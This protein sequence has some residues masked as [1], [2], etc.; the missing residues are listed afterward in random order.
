[1]YDLSLIETIVAVST[2]PGSGGIGVVRLSGP[3]ALKIARA[4]FRPKETKRKFEPGRAVLG[5]IADPGDG[6]PF[7]EG[8]LLF[9][10]APRS[11]TREDVVEFHLHGSPV[12][13]EEIVRLAVRQGARPALP[14]EFTLRAFLTGR[15]DFLQAEAV[16]DLIRSTSLAQAKSAFR[17]VEGAL[18]KKIA[19][20][21][22]GVIALIARIEAD[23]EFPEE[24]RPASKKD[25]ADKIDR[26]R[27]TVDILVRS[28]EKGKALGEGVTIALVGLANS[29]K[30]TLF[31][32][33]LEEPRAIVTPFP[34]TTRDYLR[35]IIRI[36]DA[37]FLLVD[38]AGLGRPS[39]PV[40]REGVRRGKKIAAESDGL[41]LLLD[42]SR[43]FS[44]ADGALI[45]S[46]RSRRI[47]LVLNK[48][49]LPEKTSMADVNCRFPDLPLVGISALKGNGLAELR[50]M[51]YD[52]FF[53]LIPADE[54]IVF[55]KRDKLLLEEISVRLLRAKGMILRGRPIEL[56]AEEAR[57]VVALTG[58]L[59]GEI[60]ADDILDDIFSRFCIGK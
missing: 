50:K 8:F 10:K 46:Y 58:Y 17:G 5:S 23:I 32:D 47:I 14:G 13:L 28:Y 4:L 2:P 57:E 48:T 30:S 35:E 3:A 29:G 15:L 45:E 39:S 16:D 9:F 51:I 22:D 42:G 37:S 59:T 38:M 33:L 6:R 56:A 43:R 60:R 53:H 25:Y 52:L 34:G 1:M 40:E 31:N 7:D 12:I 55:R 27:S 24:G 21:R 18:S 19:T 49:D 36:K 11:Y 54:I 44:A 41:L 26:I 20:L